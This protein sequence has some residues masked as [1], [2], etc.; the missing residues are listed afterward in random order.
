MTATLQAT[1]F[2]NIMTSRISH[3]LAD[4][5]RT[6]CGKSGWKRH[7]S[8]SPIFEMC[9]RCT[10]AGAADVV[11]ACTARIVVPEGAPRETWLAERGEGVTASEVWEIARGG[12]KTWRRILEAKM[13]GSRFNGT[14]ATRAGSSRE[15]ALLDEAADEVGIVHPNGAL[16]AAADNDLHRAT[17]DGIGIRSEAGLIV[18][19]VKSHE[20]GWK[21]DTIPADH[22][23]QVQWQIHVL[24]ATAGLYGFEVRDED[25]Q[26]PAD[27]ATWIPVPRDDEMIAWLTYRADQ[28]IAWREAGCPDVDDL[29]D[30]VADALAAW[31]PT[32]TAL[33]AAAAAEKVTNAAMKKAAAALPF[34]ERFGAVGMGEAGG[35]Q[36]TVS[37]SV[38][39][40]NAAWRAAEPETHARAEELRVE[41]AFLEAA[42]K[43]KYPQITRRQSL[44][45][46]EVESV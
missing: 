33:D 40:D 38:S 11:P 34:A 10:A 23:A 17:P 29:P 16:W 4:D 35:F 9:E 30:E 46:Q 12:V 39:I 28:F 22:L 27:G 18:V 25:D 3:V 45:F 8:A 31:A 14:A 44:R 37:E 42:A 43:R 21:L 1:A 19:E 13:N 32:K 6:L 24:G 7:A 15:A 26:P 36:I 20:Y 2:V 5:G 41:L